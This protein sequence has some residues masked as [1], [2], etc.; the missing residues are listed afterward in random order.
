MNLLQE[1]AINSMP[2]Y[3]PD[4]EQNIFG[5]G[6]DKV[7]IFKNIMRLLTDD[8]LRKKYKKEDIKED[9]IKSWILRFELEI[10]G[11]IEQILFFQ[12]FQSSK[13][14][15]T[16]RLT[17]FEQGKA[18]KL[19]KENILNLNLTMDFFY[20]K[21]SF[22]VTNMSS[23]EKIFGFEEFYKNNAVELVR[24]L[25]CK[26]ITGL[27]YSIC[28]TNIEAINIR[29]NESTRLAHK[30]YSARINSYYKQ[31]DYNKLVD[32][33]SRYNWNLNLNAKNKEWIIDDNSDLQIMARILNDDY[34]RS[35]L[36]DNEYIAIGK[37]KL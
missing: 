27:N 15:G 34:E 25:N 36:T 32:I 30:I 12:K 14:L 19:L 33:S 8:A 18:F 16:H 10:N 26:E 7:D 9:K 22:I 20:Y 31:L 21:N 28:F 17:I 4:N 37:D 1:E 6:S 29:I 5:I 2:N 13:M 35:Q 23:F 3:N 11:K 24:E